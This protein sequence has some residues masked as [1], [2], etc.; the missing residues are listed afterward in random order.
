[1]DEFTTQ[2]M[3]DAQM[4][5]VN[6]CRIYLQ[7]FHTSDIADLAG[8]TIKEWAKQGKQQSNRTS[9]WNW[10]VQQ[11]PPAEAWKNWAIALQGI[12]SEDGDLYRSIGP[13]KEKSLTHQ[14]IEW[15]M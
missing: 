4:K 13:W 7:V 3:T 1:M 6:R 10:P 14:T 8:M 9:K 11:R 12:A 2:D 5:D 15:D